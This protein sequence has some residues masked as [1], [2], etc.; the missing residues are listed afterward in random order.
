MTKRLP[1]FPCY[2][3]N[4][5]GALSSLPADEQLI[6]VVIL[7]RIY[8][9][10][11]PCP[12][13]VDALAR[14]THISVKRA[15][16]AVDALLKAGKI[17]RMEGG[18]MNPV[19]DRTLLASTARSAKLSQ[20]GFAGGKK[21]AE[22]RKQKQEPPPIEA[23]GRLKHTEKESKTPIVPRGTMA[24]RFGMPDPPLDPEA[25]L[26][27]RGKQVLG[28]NTGGLIKNLLA[29][30]GGN[31]ALARAAIEQASQRGDAREYI[32]AMVR[33]RGVAQRSRGGAAAL[34]VKMME[35]KNERDDAGNAATAG[36]DERYDPAARLPFDH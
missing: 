19:A 25:D 6:Y 26:F 21:S 5:L 32:G 31:V 36:P 14:R 7:L 34:L 1:W 33:G 24:T 17:T 2:P 23:Q 22:N 11:G 8:E 27:R 18:L 3:T 4:L 20:S 28:T 12:D 35:G 10:G 13:P 15:S 9:A 30:K 16:F 29:A